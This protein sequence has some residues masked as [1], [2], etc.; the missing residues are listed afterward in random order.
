[1]VP[2]YFC[3]FTIFLSFCWLCQPIQYDPC[4]ATEPMP[5]NDLFC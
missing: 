2:G 3:L 4:H 5:H 1:L